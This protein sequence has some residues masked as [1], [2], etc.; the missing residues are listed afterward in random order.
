MVWNALAKGYRLGMTSSSDHGSTH[1]SYSMVYTPKN[2]RQEI[3][4]AIR[5]RHT[6]GATDNLIVVARANGHFMGEEFTTAERPA[7]ELQVS[8]TDNI[9]RID[10][11]RNNAYIYTTSPLR[12]KTEVSY[13][14]MEPKEGLNYYYFRIQQDDGQ[15]AWASPLWIH[16][17]P[18]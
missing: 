13:V 7:L 6:Y 11:V 4:D 14:D 5:R 18:K 9:A 15:V 10:L 8:A 17:E 12:E 2:D 16:Y 3:L 1:I